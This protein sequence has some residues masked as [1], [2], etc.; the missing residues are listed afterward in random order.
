MI[1]GFYSPRIA[2]YQLLITFGLAGVTKLFEATSKQNQEMFPALP[3]WFWPMCGVSELAIC[4]FQYMGRVDLAMYLSFVLLGGIFAAVATLRNA[5]GKTVAQ[6]T[7]G[8]LFL[9]V[10]TYILYLRAFVFFPL[11]Q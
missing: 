3:K 7:K 11:I 5:K 6:E 4:G 8:L 1:S 9:P 10:S 2:E